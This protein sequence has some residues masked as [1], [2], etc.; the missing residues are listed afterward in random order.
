MLMASGTPEVGSK[1]SCVF[2]SPLFSRLLSSLAD[3][4]GGNRLGQV[5][6]ERT[7][8]RVARCDEP[9]D[10]DEAARFGDVLGYSR[11]KL[12][13]PRST[14]TIRF[15]SEPAANGAHPFRLPPAPSPYCSMPVTGAVSGA[16]QDWK[17][18]V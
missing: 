9:D 11:L 12:Q 17:I 14:S 18:A 5:A 3:H 13:A 2:G 16:D 8:E 7:L 6:A 10:A 15:A 1:R 4:I